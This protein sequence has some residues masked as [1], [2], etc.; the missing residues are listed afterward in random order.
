MPR[1]FSGEFGSRPHP[2]RRS[3]G[4]ISRCIRVCRSC[5]AARDS[6]CSHARLLPPSRYSRDRC[7]HRTQCRFQSRFQS[8]HR[9]R[10]G[11][12]RAAP[13]RVSASAAA[14]ASLST[15]TGTSINRPDSVGQR[16]IPPAG[17]IRRIEHHS[18]LRI[19]RPRRADSDAVKSSARSC[20]SQGING[21]G[22]SLQ[23]PLPPC[24]S[25]PSACGPA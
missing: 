11:N 12:P 15:L 7:G 14:F 22:D 19:K 25:P 20:G 17:Q 23:S 18:R 4:Q 10:S 9:K 21:A 13:Q 2:D 1:R 16:K 5:K 24:R 8:W 3:R 6:R